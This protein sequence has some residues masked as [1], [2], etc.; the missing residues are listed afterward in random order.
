MY[1][2]DE[3]WRII[4]SFHIHKIKIHGK[5]LNFKNIIYTPLFGGDLVSTMILHLKVACRELT[6]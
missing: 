1:F 5:H 6:R 4:L 3:L 2:P